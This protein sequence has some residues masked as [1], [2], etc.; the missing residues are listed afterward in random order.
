MRCLF[1]SEIAALTGFNSFCAI[2]EAIEKVVQRIKPKP[3][4]LKKRL[5]EKCEDIL[6]SDKIEDVHDKVQTEANL[7][8]IRKRFVSSLFDKEE[9]TLKKQKLIRE[10]LTT[11]VV[12]IQDKVK[13]NVSD[14]FKSLSKN[15]IDIIETQYEIAK[16]SSNVFETAEDIIESFKNIEELPGF[17]IENLKAA[18]KKVISAVDCARGVIGE[19]RVLIK[20]DKSIEYSQKAFSKTLFLEKSNVL[21]KLYGKC[22]GIEKKTGM[23]VEIKTRRN[24]LFRKAWINE[25]IQLHVYMFISETTKCKFIETNDDEVYEEIILFDEN[26]WLNVVLNLNDALQQIET[27]LKF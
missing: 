23:L 22:D 15:E 26:L 27:K 24:K 2:S 13:E 16:Q 5:I 14:S 21:V 18:E 6:K 1:A 8:K 11:S 10:A 25:L 7:V 9:S 4:S 3:L 17:C 20:F 19:K 12:P